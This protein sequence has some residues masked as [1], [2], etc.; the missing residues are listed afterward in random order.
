MASIDEKKMIF[1][2]DVGNAYIRLCSLLPHNV[3]WA[4]TMHLLM[5]TSYDILHQQSVIQYITNTWGFQYTWAVYVCMIY[6]PTIYN[7][8]ESLQVLEIPVASTTLNDIPVQEDPFSSVFDEEKTVE[9]VQC[10]FCSKRYKK[11]DGSL[12]H[13]RKR[14]PVEFRDKVIRGKVHTYCHPYRKC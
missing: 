12:K 8:A 6:D 2:S 11:S 13:C 4:V 1:F 9:D 7:I 5:S 3:H 14:H 10:N